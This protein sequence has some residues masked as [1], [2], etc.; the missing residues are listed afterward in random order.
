[1]LIKGRLEII[2]KRGK[3]ATVYDVKRSQWHVVDTFIRCPKGRMWSLGEFDTEADA[4]RYCKWLWQ[5]ACNLTSCIEAAYK[6]G[7]GSDEDNN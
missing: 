2:Y 4:T 5:E 1:M 6:A 3:Y 7:E